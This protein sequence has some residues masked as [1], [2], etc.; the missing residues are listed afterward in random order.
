MGVITILVGIGICGFLIWFFEAILKD[1]WADED[2]ESEVVYLRRERVRDD[3]SAGSS[4][5]FAAGSSEDEAIQTRH[6]H[7]A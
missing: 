4:V 1:I 6:S 7:V 5:G 3:Y 2:G